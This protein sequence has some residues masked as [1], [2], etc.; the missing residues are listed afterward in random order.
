[1]HEID[2]AAPSVHGVDVSQV[3]NRPRVWCGA[4]VANFDQLWSV[5]A[6]CGQLWGKER[7]ARLGKIYF[8]W[9]LTFER[10]AAQ[11]DVVATARL[12][13]L[14]HLQFLYEYRH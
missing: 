4:V 14:A 9:D 3:S 12:T 7:H 1:M 6:S 13:A 2:T 8:W 10:A 11:N 5:V